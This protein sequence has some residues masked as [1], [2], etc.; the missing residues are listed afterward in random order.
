MDLEVHQ[1]EMGYDTVDISPLAAHELFTYDPGF[2]STA[3]CSSGITFIDGEKGILLHQGYPIEQLAEH[4]NYVRTAYLLLHGELPNDAQYQAYAGDLAE[5]A[6]VRENLSKVIESFE[7]SA[8][9]IAKLGATLYALAGIYHH[10]IDIRD[11]KNRYYV[12]CQVVAKMPTLVAMCY[13]H[14]QGLE[15][16]Q[17]REDLDY[18]SNFLYMLFG[19]VPEPVIVEAMDKLLILHADHEQNA[20]TST[21]RLSS[22]S[23]T[24][25]FAAIAAGVAALWGPAHGGANEA[26]IKML[27]KIGDVKNIP[28]YIERAADKS[29]SFRLMG[30]GHRVYKSFDPRANVIR[31]HCQDVL[32][33]TNRTDPLLDIAQALEQ[34][35]LENEY[36]VQKK[37][38]PNVDF[39]SGIIMRA[40]N[41]PENMFTLIFALGR[42]SGWVA[43]WNEMLSNPYKIGRPRQLYSGPKQRDFPAG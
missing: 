3:A 25:P 38:Y 28:R 32:A 33:T 34:A 29:D 18:A 1:A 10:E 39:Y 5:R 2:V 4:C 13:R 17:P 31:Q 30:F 14:G 7:Q 6:L 22:S 16:L 20:S 40:L 42:S 19:E 41:L 8:H 43:H 21:V 24:N 15:F 9:P 26:V 27:E 36:F 11:Q 23:D 37:L 35:A 12:A